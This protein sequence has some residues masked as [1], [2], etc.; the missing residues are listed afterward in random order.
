MRVVVV[1]RWHRFSLMERGETQR[2]RLSA[3][4]ALSLVPEARPPPKGCWPTTA[5]L[6]LSLMEKL[7][8][9]KRSSLVAVAMA[10]A[11]AAR[12]RAMIEP[13]RAYDDTESSCRSTGRKSASYTYTDRIGPKYSVV[14]TSWLG[15]VPT[16]TVGRTKY[17]TLSS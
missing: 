12:S 11:M 4:P 9:A 13:V 2:R 16:S 3:A 1:D 7:P 17:P 5:P 8:A 15:S 6:G 10:M 14:N